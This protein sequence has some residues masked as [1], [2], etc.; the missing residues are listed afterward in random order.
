MPGTYRASWTIL[1][2]RTC[3]ARRRLAP[4]KGTAWR[5][6]SREPV[7]S[8]ACLFP[9]AGENHAAR[10]ARRA[11]FSPPTLSAYRCLWPP[12]P[13]CSAAGENVAVRDGTFSKPSW[14]RPFI[15]PICRAGGRNGGLALHRAWVPDAGAHDDLGR[16]VLYPERRFSAMRRRRGSAA[17]RH[18]SGSMTWRSGVRVPSDRPRAL[19]RSSAVTGSAPAGSTIDR[20]TRG[21]YRWRARRAGW[22]DGHSGSVTVIQE[23][24]SGLS[25]RARPRVG[26]R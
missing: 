4:A 19:D 23:F 10:T 5:S 24:S 3:A 7:P 12:P 2:K 17:G 1:G 20:R 6:P 13:P 26:A 16:D 18:V 15:A 14:K 21:W 25:L 22:A 11:L 8:S 9:R